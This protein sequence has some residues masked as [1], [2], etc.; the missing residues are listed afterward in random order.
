M[1]VYKK[2]IYGKEGGKK[3]NCDDGREE[4]SKKAFEAHRAI[5]GSRGSSGKNLDERRCK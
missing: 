1:R 4:M 3:K 5:G 2:S